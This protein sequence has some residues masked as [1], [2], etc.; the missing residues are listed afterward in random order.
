MVNGDHAELLRIMLQI[1]SVVAVIL[2]GGMRMMA[3]MKKDIADQLEAFRDDIKATMDRLFDNQDEI[4][5]DIRSLSKELT[6]LQSEHNMLWR[7]H[8]WCHRSKK[9]VRLDDDVQED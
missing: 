7:E 2:F 4:K 3:H 1:M 8:R 6:M 9:M 5:K